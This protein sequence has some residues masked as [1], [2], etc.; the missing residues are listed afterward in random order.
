MSILVIGGGKMG[1]S[2]LALISGYIGKDRV[3]LCEANWVT[4]LVFRYLGYRTFKS[5]N[6]AKVLLKHIDGVLIAT[7]TRSHA[8]MVRWAISEKI[9]FFV[10]KP[11]TLDAA[12][13]GALVTEAQHANVP[14]Q[15]GFVMRYVVTFRQLRSLVADR[16]LGPVLS[17]SATM[18]GNVAT[19]PFSK[20][21]WR[22]NFA[23]GGGCLNEYGP[24]I[25]DLCRFI[26]GPVNG[27]GEA[28]YEQVYSSAADDIIAATLKHANKVEGRIRA[29]WA[30][31]SMRKSLIEFRVNFEHAQV[32][33]DNSA[34]D[35]TWAA[36]APLSVEEKNKQES[37][38][39]PPNVGFYLRGE[40]FSLEVED[41][42]STCLDNDFHADPSYRGNSAPSLTDGCE[43]DILIEAIAK[44]AQLK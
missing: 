22:G 17:Y 43:V 40:E 19:K 1:M 16:A 32:R 14:T 26:F 25:I 33:V 29:D 39:V 28:S 30:N 20:D 41:F 13:S 5:P 27:I 31:P 36:S 35:I 18:S 24:H 4:R 3:A 42:L 2:H 8:E 15:V 38:P 23:Q 44:K 10:E 11:L 9:P 7:P 6:A 37:T 34:I 21:D 12:L